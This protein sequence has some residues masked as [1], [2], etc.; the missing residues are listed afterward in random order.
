MRLSNSGPQRNPAGDTEIII[1]GIIPE[2]DLYTVGTIGRVSHILKLPD[3]AV[4]V[5]VD[6][7]KRVKIEGYS[8]RDDFDEYTDIADETEEDEELAALARAVSSF[9][10][11]VKLNKKITP[12]VIVS[13]NQIEEP[14][15]LSVRL[16]PSDVGQEKQELLEL[17]DTKDRLEKIWLYGRRD[18]CSSN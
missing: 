14:A 10:Q 13:I 4:K 5:L 3:G 2:D 1:E 11:Y 9:E 12:E 18:R 15:K 6:G 7:V 8:E 17:G 16:R